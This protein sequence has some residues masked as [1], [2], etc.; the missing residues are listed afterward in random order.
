[1]RVEGDQ[2]LKPVLKDEDVPPVTQPP[3]RTA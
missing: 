1:M 3:A 2:A